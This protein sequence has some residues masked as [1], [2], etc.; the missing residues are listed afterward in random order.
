[1]SNESVQNLPQKESFYSNLSNT[2]K[3]NLI[4]ALVEDISQGMT[5]SN[6]I[7]VKTYKSQFQNRR[8]SVEQ[9]MF[10]TNQQSKV[11]KSKLVSSLIGGSLQAVKRK[12][13]AMFK[14]SKPFC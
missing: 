4:E 6:K 2:N 9:V 13:G 7:V 14:N 11:N 8:R 10:P 5:T 12:M 1:M 3:L